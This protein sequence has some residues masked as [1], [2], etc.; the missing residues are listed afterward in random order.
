MVLKM[1]VV[2]L[3]ARVSV[4]HA[5]MM[6]IEEVVDFPGTKVLSGQP[7]SGCWD[8]NGVL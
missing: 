4:A 2:C 3:L 5:L 7:I 8:L 1:Y 6:L